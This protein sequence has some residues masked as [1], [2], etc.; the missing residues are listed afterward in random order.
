VLDTIALGRSLGLWVEVVTLV[1]PGLNQDHR[2][3]G[4]L[5]NKLREIDPAI[6]WHLNGFVPRY[7][8][9]DAP[10]ADAMTLMMAAGAAYAAG[11]RF[12]YVGN[13]PVARELAH[14][15]CPSCH[16]VAISRQDYTTTHNRIVDGR[17]PA[18]ARPL[19]GIW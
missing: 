4:Q 2:A 17:C 15:R 10:A 7:R 9:K 14:T 8:M 13:S 11:S 5:G 1:V 6:P 19:P 12:V 3:L 16:H 18:C